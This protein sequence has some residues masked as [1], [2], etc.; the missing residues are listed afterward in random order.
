MRI[1]LPVAGAGLNKA[2]QG[3]ADAELDF[4]RTKALYESQAVA[5]T[6]FEQAESMLKNASKKSKREIAA[7]D[8]SDIFGL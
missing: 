4:N 6:Q 2:Q 8:I 7:K 3:L 5:K 1:A